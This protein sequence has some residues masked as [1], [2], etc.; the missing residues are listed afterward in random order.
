MV[1]KASIWLD[2][3]QA[4]PSAQFPAQYA[5]YIPL[6]Y[7][8]SAAHFA[9]TGDTDPIGEEE[10]ATEWDALAEFADTVPT[11]LP[12]LL[13]MIVYAAACSDKDS[14]AFTDHN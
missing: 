7:E 4:I 10:F 2:I 12:G 8:C 14:D 6:L 1:F 5:H 3:E 11:T 9:V 13:A